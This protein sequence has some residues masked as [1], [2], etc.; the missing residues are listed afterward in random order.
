MA[1]HIRTL[2]LSRSILYLERLADYLRD[3]PFATQ[4]EG[5]AFADA[6]LRTL[7]PHLKESR[8]P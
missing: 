1:A 8:S 2:G 7:H 4:A 6:L 3:H 5:E